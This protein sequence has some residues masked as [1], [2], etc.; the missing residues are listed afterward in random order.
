MECQLFEACEKGD[1]EKLRKLMSESDYAVELLQDTHV[2]DRGKVIGERTIFAACLKGH[3]TTVKILLDEGVN[4][5]VN[6][7]QG[8]PIYAAAKIGNLKI[9]QVLID[10]GA[11]FRHMKGGFSPLFAASL[12]GHLDVLKFLVRRTGISVLQLESPQY[13]M[14][15]CANGHVGVVK[16]LLE[17]TN[18]NLNKTLKGKDVLKDDKDSLLHVACNQNQ[19]EVAEFLITQGAIITKGVV[20]RFPAVI[21]GVMERQITEY[22]PAASAKGKVSTQFQA[23]WSGMSLA[24]FPGDI[25][26]NFGKLTKVDLKRN[27][28][29]SVPESLFMLASLQVLDLSHNSLAELTTEDCVWRCDQ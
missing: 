16:W 18:F 7:S 11:E 10:W 6:S 13:L 9:V 20:A 29:E 27:M 21:Q 24:D 19:L 8:T 14:N 22:K 15:A 23:N 12:Y 26:M 5:N 3:L 4:V 1:D 17:T 28:L 25:F 2:P